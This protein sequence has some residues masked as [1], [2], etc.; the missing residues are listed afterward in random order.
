MLSRLVR[1]SRYRLTGSYRLDGEDQ[2]IW[3]TGL[4]VLDFSIRQRIRRWV[5]YY[6]ANIFAAAS[7]PSQ[8][9]SLIDK[10]TNAAYDWYGDERHVCTY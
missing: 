7:I 1:L 2:T 3:A 4:D 10:S 5:D 8:T 6:H 9:D